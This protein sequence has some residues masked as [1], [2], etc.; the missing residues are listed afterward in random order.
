[1]AGPLRAARARVRD[2]PDLGGLSADADLRHSTDAEPGIARRRAGRGFRY[3]GPDGASIRD[4]AT[5]ARIRALAIPPAWEDVWICRDPRGHLQAAGRDV[6]GRKQ[7]R[8][9]PAWRA[10]RD[11]S[12]Y[13]RIAAFGRALPRVRRRVAKDLALPTLSKEKV[14]ATVVRLLETTSMRIG[15]EA[16]A[17][18]NGSFG[19]TTLRNRHVTV[20]GDGLRFRFR[21]KSG[22][23]HE[24]GVRDRRLARIVARCEALPGQELFQYL[25]EDG[26]PRGIASTDVNGY[27][28]G[29]AGIPITAKDFRTWTGT[30]IAFHEL[31]SRPGP[32]TAVVRPRAMVVRSAEVVAE[33]LGNTPA[34]SRQS[35]I[36]PVV[37][38]AYLA[39]SLPRSRLRR[40]DPGEQTA[41]PISRREEL[42]L[43]HFLERG[44]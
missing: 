20:S 30:L 38:E 12:K 14:L 36:A 3:E 4:P 23:V 19:L 42:A 28:Q 11:E 29:A 37:V 40:P 16:Y 43:L 26:E 2:S 22:K 24:V 41:R 13:G 9:H 44:R 17:R 7:S 6:R 39:G 1:M 15:S 33:V 35:Y 21:G 31:R 34:V 5:L 8:Y 25:D 18:S 32:H 10:R 27:L